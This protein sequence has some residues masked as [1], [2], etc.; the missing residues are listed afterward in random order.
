MK[1][2]F[3]LFLLMLFV[4][5]TK[6]SPV[7]SEWSFA[8]DS[9]YRWD[10]ISNRATLGGVN[11]GIK[12]STQKMRGIN[13]YQLG[14][15]GIWN[16]IECA[17]IRGDGH[18]GWTGK[19]KYSE[20][21][22]F[23]NTKG[24]TFDGKGALGYFFCVAPSIW[25][26][27]VVGY[28]YD[29]L[30]LKATNIHVAINDVVYHRNNIKAHQSFQGPFV[31]FDLFFDINPCWDFAFS[32][33]FHFARWRGERLIQGREYGNPPLFGTTTAYSNTRRLNSAYGNVFN[34]DL[35]YQFCDCWRLGL[36]LKYQFYNGDGGK[37]KQTRRPIMPLYT[38]ANVDGLR[39][40]SFASIITLGRTF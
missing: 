13:S 20:G 26:A 28:S 19:G 23:G 24:Y 11:S 10:R 38:Y 16:F 21:G 4:L 25:A 2:T 15:R 31:G 5:L 17:Y 14:G 39:W 37:Y 7:Q 33:E 32:Y 6:A 22:Y 27:P 29:A 18:Y 30:N 9:G 40:L 1:R 36:D 35:G 34:F 8:I 12:G 3:P